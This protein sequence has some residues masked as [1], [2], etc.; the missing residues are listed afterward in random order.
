M[1]ILRFISKF[2]KFYGHYSPFLMKL[3]KKI[4]LTWFYLFLGFFKWDYLGIYTSKYFFDA[5]FEITTKNWF[6]TQKIGRDPC[7][8]K[9][10]RTN[11]PRSRRTDGRTPRVRTGYAKKKFFFFFLYNYFKKL[12]LIFCDYFL[13]NKRF[14]MNWNWWKINWLY[15]LFQ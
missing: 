8:W 9:I 10:F 7:T 15:Q 14:A 4:I 2:T 1:D 13:I 3:S 5:F 12:F 6:Y 11:R